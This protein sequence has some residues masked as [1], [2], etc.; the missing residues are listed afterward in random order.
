MYENG[1]CN[2]WFDYQEGERKG[3]GGK[4]TSI[5]LY[6][7]TKE[8]PKHGEARPWK[9]G[10]EPLCPFELHHEHKDNSIIQIRLEARKCPD[11]YIQVMQVIQEKER[12]PKFQNGT[13]AYKH[14]AIVNYALKENLKEFGWSLEPMQK[15]Q[16][17]PSRRNP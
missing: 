13:D 15:E 2:V 10:D 14:N 12:Q 5:L 7:Y 3:R 8:K 1:F 6:I 11:S 16:N 4:V 17:R 9:K